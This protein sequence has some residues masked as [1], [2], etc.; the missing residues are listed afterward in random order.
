MSRHGYAGTSIRMIAAELG[1]SPASIFNLFSSKQE[2]LNEVIIWCIAPLLVFYKKL[3]ELGL[4]PEVA[5]YKSIYEDVMAMAKAEQDV[6]AIFYL[7]ELRQ[8]EFAPASDIRAKATAHY[9][10]LIKAG[11]KQGVFT[12]LPAVFSA[13]QIFQLTETSIL[14]SEQALKL[15]PKQQATATAT[16]CLRGLLNDASRLDEIAEEAGRIDLVINTVK[17]P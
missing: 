5:M 7:P 6:P 14:A 11:Q 13:E 8:P 12:K 9:Q 4:S 10:R 1:A 3:M 2:I 15:S 17:R 16:F